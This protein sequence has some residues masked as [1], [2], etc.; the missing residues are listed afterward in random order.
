MRRRAIYHWRRTEE[1]LEKRHKKEGRGCGVKSPSF[2]LS[3][4]L[5]LSTLCQLTTQQSPLQ[6]CH[7]FSP[8]QPPPPSI[9]TTTA[10]PPEAFVPFISRTNTY[11]CSGK[12]DAE[13]ERISRHM[14]LPN[15]YLF[16]GNLPL[17]KQKACLGAHARSGPIIHRKCG[18]LTV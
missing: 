6:C 18:Q 4:I 7:R 5:S 14:L 2:S 17:C 8:S 16:G 9:I 1:R 3:S 13:R 11:R 10:G 12:D 15:D